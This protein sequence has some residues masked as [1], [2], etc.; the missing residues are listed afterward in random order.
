[1]QTGTSLSTLLNNLNISGMEREL[2]KLSQVVEV[3]FSE[4]SRSIIFFLPSTGERPAFNITKAQ[5]ELLRE[6]AE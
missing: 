2:E 3:S 6:T 4:D 1:M 5:I